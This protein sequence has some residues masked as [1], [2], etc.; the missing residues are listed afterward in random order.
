MAP[1]PKK[2]KR[3][4]RLRLRENKGTGVSTDLIC[5]MEKVGLICDKS[6]D[7]GCLS[8]SN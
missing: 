4:R 1:R 6:L 8:S 2:T 7:Y 3:W 5:Q